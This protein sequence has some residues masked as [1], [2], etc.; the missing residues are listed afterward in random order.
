MQVQISWLLQKPTDLDLHCLQR[1]G[2][3][4]FSRTRVKSSQLSEAEGKQ[5][6]PGH[7]GPPW[8]C[9]PFERYQSESCECKIVRK[10]ST[11][12]RDFHDHSLHKFNMTKIMLKEI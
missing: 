7:S 6:C 12:H 9:I 10:I 1:Q 11:D 3:S 8:R 5:V 4:G 2:I